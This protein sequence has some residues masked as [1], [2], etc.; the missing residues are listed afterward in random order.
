MLNLVA[1][2]GYVAGGIFH[3][4]GDT[5]F[6]L[7]IYRDPQR[8]QKRKLATN[9]SYR[10]EPD[11]VSCR[12]PLSTFTT[13][14]A[15]EK[16]MEVRITGY[17]E[18]RYYEEKLG[19]FVKRAKGPVRMLSIATDLLNL[20]S[21]ERVSTEVVVESFN[22]VAMP[23]RGERDDKLEFHKVDDKGMPAAH[24]G[25]GALAASKKQKQGMP[26]TTAKNDTKNADEGS[27]QPSSEVPLPVPAPSV[28]A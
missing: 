9:G 12:F 16:G 26:P 13:P 28:Q 11:Y 1:V 3:K 22:L 18:S 6:R 15:L 27:G 21:I 4:N 14:M 17:M 20:I 25:Q 23:K 8:P 10:D 24:T 5:H 2:Q 19:E 7:G